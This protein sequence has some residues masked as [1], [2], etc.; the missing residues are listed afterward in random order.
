MYTSPSS[1]KITRPD[2]LGAFE[3]HRLFRIFDQAPGPIIWVTGPPG[4]GKTTL[5][6]NWVEARRVPCLWY[7]IDEDDNDPAGFFYHM[8]L[9]AKKAAPR[10][11]RP[12]PL[13]TPEYLLGIPT[14]SRRFFENLYG[15]LITANNN[16]FPPVVVFDNYQQVSEGSVLH[17][18]LYEGLCLIPDG[19]KVVLISRKAP[20]EVLIRLR[21]NRLMKVI[22]W[23]ELKFT[24]EES[25]EIVSHHGH[26]DVSSDVIKLIH[27]KTDGWAAGIVLLLEGAR[28][29]G[30]KSVLSKTQTSKEILQ[31]FTNEI[32][33][34]AEQE[35]QDFLLKTHFLPQMSAKMA[36]ALTGDHHASR[37]L[38]DLSERNFFTQRFESETTFFQYHPLFRE[39]LR[40]KAYETFPGDLV[41]LKKKAAML[42]EENGQ[43]EDAFE[44]FKKAE[45][46]P[47]AVQLV[48]KHAPNL[49]GQGRGQTLDG[50]INAL[51][52]VIVESAPWL[53]YWK[54]ICLL[55]SSPPESHAQF[56]KAF[57]LFRAARDAAGIFLSLSGIFDS[58]IFSFGTYKPFDEAL[59]LFDEV[60]QEY[61]DFPSPEIEARLTASRLFAILNRDPSH[62]D[63]KKMV[64]RALSI[65]QVIP[66]P[67][68]K[69][70]LFQGLLYQS[71][72]AGE[73]QTAGSLVDLV[74][75]QVLSRDFSP[76]LR[77]WFKGYEAFFYSF[78]AEF[79]KCR[80]AVEEGLELASRTGVRVM[81]P[82]LHA[83]GA[84]A[85]LDLGDL[86]AADP[87]IRTMAN[88]L[89]QGGPNLVSLHHHL[90]WWKLFLEGEFSKS[91]THAESAL[92]LSLDAGVPHTVAVARIDCALALHELNRDDEAMSHLAESRAFASSSGLRYFD[93]TCFLMEARFAFDKGDDFTGLIS[94]RKALSIGNEK[95]FMNVHL[96]WIPAMMA[97][98]CQ[99]ALE[100]GIEVDYVRRLIRKRN[101]MPDPPPIDCEQWPWPLRIYTLGR[102]EIVRHG[103]ALQF[104]G[105]V[106]KRPL[107]LLKMLVSNGGR[108]ISEEY[109][110][111]CLWP[112]A[113]GD[114]ASGTLRTTL[115]RLRKLL[116]V[117]GA[118]RFQEGKASLDP[119]CCW[120]DSQAFE[121]M[122]AQ[123]EKAIEEETSFFQGESSKLL[124]FVEM[125]VAIYRGHFLP[126]DEGKFWSISYRERLRSRFS[127]L[128]TMTG[129]LL[130]RKGLWGKALEFYQKGLEAD[131]LSEEL[132]QRV[133]VCCNQLGRREN[134]LETYRRCKT[135][136]SNKMGIEPSEKTKALYRAV[137]ESRN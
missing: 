48:L 94:L 41:R 128:I 64:E 60:S 119:R 70:Q 96:L 80:E 57:D 90:C 25:G 29:G 33:K 59:A 101:L 110:G 23:D 116:G 114:V 95:E 3:R 84:V 2:S 79:Q 22:G 133:M 135:L 30:I 61:P 15:R 111:D 66:D 76:L 89:F 75:K 112:D 62:P 121:K 74:R 10:K 85:A 24:L 118:I 26:R 124:R 126:A 109:I 47:E 34:R 5:V 97:E 123:F 82:H 105:K 86:E 45:A 137:M 17:Q 20:P 21:A 37:I 69:M 9:A 16:G 14:F 88:S 81:D 58:I 93:F 67:N 102:F 77:I 120:V 8:G 65:F 108:E 131:D 104:L 39:F 136:L 4:A 106:Q 1:A 7:Q 92:E 38:L 122:L 103:E 12:L 68:I 6:A 87:F 130:E 99:K 78:T 40:I 100:A 91:L 73:F 113:T 49:A 115:S 43:P 36:E 42:L 18:I 117:D 51:P 107:E 35:L 134:A 132:Y 50:W 31:Y 72:L 46:W 127:R 129:D 19:T 125:A 32:F 28:S 54:G 13:L 98:L 52:N 56:Q 83:Y 27:E 11:R 71:L 55:S 63:L 44:L 53:L